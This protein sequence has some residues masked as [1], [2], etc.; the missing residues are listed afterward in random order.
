VLIDFS[1]LAAN[2]L[3]AFAIETNRLENINE[4]EFISKSY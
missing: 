3:F 2:L 1:N 4:I